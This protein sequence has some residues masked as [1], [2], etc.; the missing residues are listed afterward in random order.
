MGGFQVLFHP[1]LCANNNGIIDGTETGIEDVIV[2]LYYFN[3]NTMNYVLI[4]STTT[5]ANGLYLFDWRSFSIAAHR[6]GFRR[7]RT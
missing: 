1:N 6:C 5:D 4:Q 2:D 7:Q 3:P